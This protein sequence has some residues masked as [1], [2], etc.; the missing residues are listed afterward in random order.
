[1]GK[2]FK[3]NVS[4]YHQELKRIKNRNRIKNG[5]SSSDI[6][7][8]THRG[9]REEWYLS[10]DDVFAANTGRIF[11]VEGRFKASMKRKVRSME[12][13][14]FLQNAVALLASK[15]SVTI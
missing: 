11:S 8:T 15:I 3:R 1:M 5:K 10:A 13:I 2:V 7:K 4:V 14:S 9:K 12:V 6:M